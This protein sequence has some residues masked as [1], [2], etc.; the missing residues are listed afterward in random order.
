VTSEKVRMERGGK[1]GGTWITFRDKSEKLRK[2]RRGRK[3]IGGK[4]ILG[5]RR[6]SGETHRPGP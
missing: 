6:F 1:R 2:A 5:R 3:V 4:R